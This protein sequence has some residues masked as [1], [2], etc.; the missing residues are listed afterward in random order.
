MQGKQ[1][2]DL[3]YLSIRNGM[4]L[5]KVQIHTAEIMMRFAITDTI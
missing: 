5:G 2:K 3:A 4:A 1:L